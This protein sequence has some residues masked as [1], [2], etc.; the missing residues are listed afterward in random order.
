MKGYPEVIL[1]S[2]AS[3]VGIFGKFPQ[4]RAARAS[5]QERGT[6]FS[7]PTGGDKMAHWRETERDQPIQPCNPERR[8]RD[9]K[10]KV[11]AG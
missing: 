5:V 1:R 7:W 10:P 2:C 3:K 9:G 11:V 6:H 8:H 4:L